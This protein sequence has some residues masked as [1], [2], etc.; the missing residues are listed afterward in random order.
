[1]SVRM[2]LFEFLH[3]LLNIVESIMLSLVN[4]AFLP[5][6]VKLFQEEG[7]FVSH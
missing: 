3:S 7:V 4:N 6:R 2:N 1:M 5:L